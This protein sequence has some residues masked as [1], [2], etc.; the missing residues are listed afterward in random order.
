MFQTLPGILA[1][2]PQNFQRHIQPGIDRILQI[3]QEALHQRIRRRAQYRLAAVLP[4]YETDLA[5]PLGTPAHQDAADVGPVI[6]LSHRLLH[7]EPRLRRERKHLGP[8]DEA[9]HRRSGDL[10]QPGD[11]VDVDFGRFGFHSLYDLSI[12]NISFTTG[13]AYK[14]HE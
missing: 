10:R 9:R 12:I 2:D 4:H 11:G 5:A 8:V 13:I 14:F 6:Q 1:V 7:A 3:A